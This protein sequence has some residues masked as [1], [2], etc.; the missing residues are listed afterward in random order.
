MSWCTPR[1]DAHATSPEASKLLRQLLDP[2]GD[3]SML[4][5]SAKSLLQS[6]NKVAQHRSEE[7]PLQLKHYPEIEL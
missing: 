6:R 3:G 2:A 7:C 4:R 5:H 1:E